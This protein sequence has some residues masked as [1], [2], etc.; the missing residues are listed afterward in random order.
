MFSFPFPCNVLN[1]RQWA[2][3]EDWFS[4]G[5]PTPQE[6][7]VLSALVT[8]TEPA[9]RN[10]EP[11]TASRDKIHSLLENSLGVTLPL[12]I[13]LSRP[14]TLKTAQKSAFSSR[15][16]S[17][18][19]EHSLKSFSIRPKELAWHPNESKTRWFL[20][21]RLEESTEL[22]TLLDICNSV[23]KEFDQPLLYTEDEVS[24]GDQFHI[25]IAWAL[26]PP[27]RSKDQEQTSPEH[28][29]AVQEEPAVPNENI[30]RLSSLQVHFAEVKARIGQDVDVIKL[31]IIRWTIED[32]AAPGHESYQQN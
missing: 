2:L 17:A 10:K 16:T 9:V 29:M 3:D 19:A 32:T 7:D 26:Q 20:V 24:K 12:H 25:S 18:I 31:K 15:L 23:A 5:H 28:E 14:L 22:T 8:S 6:H 30:E 11:E 27:V 1:G 4:R 13:S 21:I